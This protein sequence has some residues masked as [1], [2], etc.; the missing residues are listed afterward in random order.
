MRI[1]SATDNRCVIEVVFE[2]LG[3]L[4][5]E[6]AGWLWLD[7]EVQSTDFTVADFLVRISVVAGCIAV[8]LWLFARF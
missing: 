5:G 8:V 4:V 6:I 2:L 1:D 3:R 7:R